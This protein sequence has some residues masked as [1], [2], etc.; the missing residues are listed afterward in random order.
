MRKFY[1][2]L[3]KNEKLEIDEILKKTESDIFA[4]NVK[5]ISLEEFNDNIEN[6]KNKS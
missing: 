5:T 1:H 2:L 4:G 3:L 6:K